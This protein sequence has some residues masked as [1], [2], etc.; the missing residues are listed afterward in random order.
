MDIQT[1]LYKT[2]GH[3]SFRPLQ[4]EIVDDILAG[5]DLLAVLP[6]GA[7]KSLCYQLPAALLPGMVLVISPLVSLMKDQVDRVPEGLTALWINSTLTPKNLREALARLDTEP[8]DLL[9]LAPERL[10][11][12]VFMDVLNR[13][14]ISLVAV[15][16][17]HCVSRWGHDFRPTYR[18][19]GNLLKGFTR[20]PP[21]AAFTATASREVR[22]DIIR[23]LDLRNPGIHQAGFDR[24]GLRLEVVRD[25]DRA[26]WVRQFLSTGK[27]RNQSGILYCSTRKEVEKYSRLLSEEGVPHRTYHGGMKAA[28]RHNSQEDFLTGSVP[29]MVATNAFGMGIDKP[30]IR[31]IV[32]TSMPGDLESYYQE[33]GRAG[34]DGRPAR[35]ILLYGAGDMATQQ[36]LILKGSRYSRDKDK[37]PR[38]LKAMLGYCHT[39]RCLREYLLSHFG[40]ED[41][42]RH[43]ANC[44]NCL[45][46]LPVTDVTR[47]AQMV[48]S[49]VH[50]LR[51]RFGTAAV[52]QVLKGSRNAFVRKN[53]LEELSTFGLLKNRSPEEIRRILNLL[54]CRGLVE[55]TAGRFPR[56]LLG[57]EAGGVLRGET[58]I[59]TKIIC[60]ES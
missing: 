50:Y 41:I 59:L 34:R 11:D 44:S 15:D 29:V 42:P 4:R 55:I 9:Y 56:V 32:H 24:P 38:A 33:A 25:C 37:K 52:V 53:S 35:C 54:Y 47:E 26:A 51:G 21:V 2:F 30:D 57:P 18:K 16:E 19:I 22:E 14:R 36:S 58:R 45:E 13:I 31:W 17:A 28:D 5:R 60:K 7:G 49:T 27:Q 12:P 20:R 43:C 46:N 48:L 6:T 10:K 39:S 40:Q 1:T 3:R 23:Q 8:F